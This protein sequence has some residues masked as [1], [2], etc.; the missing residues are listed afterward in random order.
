[1]DRKGYCPQRSQK[2]DQE[3]HNHLRHL[4]SNISPE[5][6]PFVQEHYHPCNRKVIFIFFCRFVVLQQDKLSIS[7]SLLKMKYPLCGQQSF[8]QSNKNLQ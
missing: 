2:G 4:R 8:T 3:N 1:M 6:F 5:A 7:T